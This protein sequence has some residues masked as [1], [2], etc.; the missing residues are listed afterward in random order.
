[1]RGADR[2]VAVA[3]LGLLLF[4]FVFSWVG[5]NVAGTLPGSHISGAGSGVTG[6]DAFT[7][8]RWVWLLTACVALAAVGVRTVGWSPP[9]SILPGAVVALLGVVSALLIGFRIVHHPTAHAGFG[10][11]HVSFGI[12]PGI[13][14]A[15]AAALAIAGG[16][17]LQ[18]REETKADEPEAEA[19]DEPADDA[20]AGFTGLTVSDARAKHDAP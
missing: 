19:A 3:A 8:S 2:L 6:W 17:C 12:K 14:L 15:F 7:N 4:T 16:G 20:P 18:L 10:G 5:E 9:E 1:M 13:W 11:F